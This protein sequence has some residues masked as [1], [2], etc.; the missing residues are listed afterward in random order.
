M[1]IPVFCPSKFG[2][3]PPVPADLS[4]KTPDNIAFGHPRRS[5]GHKKAEYGATYV[6]FDEPLRLLAKLC[7]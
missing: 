7:D 5:N 3:C 1:M 4:F 6:V 2:D